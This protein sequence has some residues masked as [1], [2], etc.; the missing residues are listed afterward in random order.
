MKTWFLIHTV[1][2]TARDH[3]A[4]GKA[5]SL[6]TSF[7]SASKDWAKAFDGAICVLGDSVLLRSIHIRGFVL[8]TTF[9]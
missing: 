6:R 4:M 7:T 9:G 1:C 8:D 2:V 5:F 3:K